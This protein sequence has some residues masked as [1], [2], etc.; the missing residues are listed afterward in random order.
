MAG[1][2]GT[3][4]AGGMA[5]KQ[6][7]NGGKIFRTNPWSF[8]KSFVLLLFVCLFFLPFSSFFIYLFTCFLIGGNC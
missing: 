5:L 8:L 4:E 7:Q 3:V 1:A 2:G 6:N